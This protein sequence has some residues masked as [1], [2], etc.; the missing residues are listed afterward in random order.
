[1]KNPCISG[2]IPQYTKA[3]IKKIA[4]IYS[5]DFITNLSTKHLIKLTTVN[6]FEVENFHYEEDAYKWLSECT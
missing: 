3:G 6:T 4:M 5:D 1:M 2:L